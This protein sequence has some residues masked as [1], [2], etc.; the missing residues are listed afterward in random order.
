MKKDKNSPERRSDAR[1]DITLPVKIGSGDYDLIT[2][3]KNIS[4]SGIYCQVS[5]YI[6]VMTKLAL[7]MHVPLIIGKRKVEK[8]VD[9]TC[10]VVR[11]MPE[12]IQESLN[13]YDIGLFFSQIQEKDQALISKYIQQAF[14]VGLN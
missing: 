3:T 9:C 10:V 12:F 11:I 2:N 6:P 8:K 4:C 13:N 7:T 14:F 1:F 5:R